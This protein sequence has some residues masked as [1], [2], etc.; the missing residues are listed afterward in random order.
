M[1]KKMNVPTVYYAQNYANQPTARPLI[2][3]LFYA[4]VRMRKRGIR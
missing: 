3:P 4:S 2:T 1:Q